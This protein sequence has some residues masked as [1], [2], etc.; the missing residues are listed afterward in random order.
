L[1]LSHLTTEVLEEWYAVCD[2]HGYVKPQVIQKGYSAIS[3]GDEEKFIPLVREHGSD[4]HAF[5]FVIFAP[6]CSYFTYTGRT[7]DRRLNPCDWGCRISNEVGNL[8]M[9]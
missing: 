5:R 4:Y 3:R 7:T 2:K 1:G 6:P 8:A 9:C